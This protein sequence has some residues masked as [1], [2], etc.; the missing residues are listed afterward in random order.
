MTAV[1]EGIDDLGRWKA[2]KAANA[3]VYTVV[4]DGRETDVAS[5]DIRVGD[6]LKLVANDEVPADCVLLSSSDAQGNA[7]IQT[8]NLDGESNLKVRSAIP[9]TKALG[10]PAALGGFKG[11]VE[12]AP[13]N[14]HIY[15][16]DS[17]LRMT[18]DPSATNLALSSS[19]LLLQ[20][21]HVRNVDWL[22]AL[23]VYT[24]NESKFGKNKRPPPT[25]YTRT[26]D[27]IQQVTKGIFAFQL[28]MVLITG[29]I[30]DTWERVQFPPSKA[31][32][33]LNRDP[34]AKLDSGVLVIPLRFLLLNSTMIPISLKLTLDLCKLFYAKFID[35]DVHLYDEETDTPAHSNSTALSEDLGQVAYILTDKT[36][37]LTENRMVLKA[38]SVV[39]GRD[40][41]TVPGVPAPSNS[42]SS[43]NSD[44]PTPPALAKLQATGILADAGLYGRVMSETSGGRAGISGGSSWCAGS[45]A[46]LM[47]CLALNNDVVPGVNAGG[48]RVYKASSPDEEAL[49]K[50][51]AG[52][53][54]V[55]WAREGD[56]VTIQTGGGS[57]VEPAQETYTQLAAFE[58][59][60]DRKR[61]SVLL[62]SEVTG[63]IRLYCKGADDM[64]MAR[65]APGQ[66]DVTRPL[67]A[68]IDAYAATGLRTLVMSYRDISDAEL[69]E[70]SSAYATASAAMTD[71]DAAK[72]RVYDTMERN[73]T[74]VGATAIED[75][76][77][78]GVPETIALLRR[79]G[80][81]FWMLTG[82][83]FSTALTIARTCNLKTRE[84]ALIE[85][86]GETQEEVCAAPLSITNPSLSLSKLLACRPMSFS[87]VVTCADP[88]RNITHICFRRFLPAG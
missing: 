70:F 25:K 27:F 49:V 28:L 61:M 74:L 73:L 47:R 71:R 38:V 88:S 42:S 62:R 59:S 15:K 80:V 66:D 9:E 41:G 18:S 44:G 39:G 76:L 13:P 3:R 48:E 46:E 5:A 60:S 33:L 63:R 58:F 53:G 2:D 37:T 54:A 82:D 81:A 7:F 50:A 83:K 65:L 4:R 84:T 22:Y 31:W 77:Q 67:Q 12:C 68:R 1:K 57:G 86:E 32:Y 75:K 24:G 56:V 23:V 78:E 34:A 51:A 55:L 16:F 26:D 85:I 21:T 20:A 79:A 64:I 69:A 17:R 29:I 45:H 40:Y 10:T 35:A 52:Y 11:V 14:E 87:F 30:G 36:G 72:E 8:T 19:Q 43:G 6:V